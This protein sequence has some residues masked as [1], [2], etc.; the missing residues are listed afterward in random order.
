MVLH[1]FRWH[2]VFGFITHSGLYRWRVLPYGY[3]GSSGIFCMVIDGSLAGLKW[4]V[5]VSYV[6]DVCCYGRSS[7]TAHL[8]VLN[9]TFDRL[10]RD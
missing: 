10:Q 2:S 5:L 8:R 6:D 7:F 1:C 4:Q 9:T 3:K